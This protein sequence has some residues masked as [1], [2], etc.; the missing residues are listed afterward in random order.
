M[1]AHFCKRPALVAST[2]GIP[3]MVAY[4]S[5]DCSLL[6][7]NQSEDAIAHIQWLSICYSKIIVMII[8]L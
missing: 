2:F 5:F 8:F 3:E 4:E 1:R 7:E 6:T